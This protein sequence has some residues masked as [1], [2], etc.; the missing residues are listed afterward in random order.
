[1]IKKYVTFSGSYILK[2][3]FFYRDIFINDTRKVILV[4]LEGRE[5]LNP[6]LH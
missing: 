5:G 3:Q 4:T 1:M 6:P 2:K